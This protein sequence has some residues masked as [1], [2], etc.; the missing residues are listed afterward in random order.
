MHQVFIGVVL[1]A[2]IGLFAWGRLRHDFVALIALFLLVVTGTVP[3]E[4]AFLGFGH[5]AV[6]TVA[7]VLVLSRAVDSSGAMDLLGRWIGGIGGRL[8]P[9]VL[10]TLL[11]AVASM[12]MNNV[13]ALALLMPVAVHLARQN[14]ESPSLYLMPLAFASLLGGMGTLIGT[15]PNI[16][17]ATYRAR[18]TGTAFGMFAYT[19]VGVVLTVAGLLFLVLAGRRLLPKRRVVKSA[20]DLFDIDDYITEIKI[21]AKSKA[22]G[23]SLDAL[24]KGSKAEVSILG[25]A[26]SIGACLDPFLMCV[27]VG[28]SSA[29]LTPIGHQSNTLVMA[30]GGYAFSDYWRL[31]LPL[32][33]LVIVVGVPVILAVWPM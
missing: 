2:A 24:L 25:L 27:A 28:A 29:F 14:K 21:P 19:P 30:P 5:P 4:R 6:I 10:L 22:I 13:G 31:G 16:I 17:I 32:S 3:A 12:F 1:V 23:L 9:I 8:P 15:P 7:A 33:I 20:T 11:A 26:R 18:E